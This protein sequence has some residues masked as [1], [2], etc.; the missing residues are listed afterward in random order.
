MLHI[1]TK[2]GLV[3]SVIK[4]DIIYFKSTPKFLIRRI[5]PGE[6]LSKKFE[7]IVTLIGVTEE[8]GNTIQVI[9]NAYNEGSFINDVTQ[10]GGGELV[11]F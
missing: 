5:F 1:H 6:L 8:T 3:Q 2:T 10:H 4:T 11:H 7:I 9:R